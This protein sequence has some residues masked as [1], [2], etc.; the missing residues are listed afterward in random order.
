[1]LVAAPSLPA[2]PGGPFGGEAFLSWAYAGSSA[3]LDG[4]SLGGAKTGSVE[5]SEGGHQLQVSGLG[6]CA[7]CSATV[8]SPVDPATTLVASPASIVP[9]GSSRLS[10]TTPAGSF[11]A[12]LIDRRLGEKPASGQTTVS[13]GGTTTWRRLVL[14]AQ[15]GA[16]AEETVA[17]GS[18]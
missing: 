9:G 11:L 14:T 2:A 17:V 4:D 15:G 10:W 8:L 18:P 1:M 12:S 6:S 13:P 3:S 7:R 16:L 5:E